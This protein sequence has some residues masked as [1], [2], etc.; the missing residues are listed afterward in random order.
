MTQQGALRLSHSHLLLWAGVCRSCLYLHT[1][2]QWRDLA[3]PKLFALVGGLLFYFALLQRRLSRQQR[4]V[5][6][7]SGRGLS[8]YRG[9]LCLDPVLLT[10]AR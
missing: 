3:L 9:T 7:L 2:P 4:Y 5:R 6:F 1:Q 10:D 8:V